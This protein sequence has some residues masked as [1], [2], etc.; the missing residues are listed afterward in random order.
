MKKIILVN[1]FVT[2]QLFCFSQNTALV[3]SPQNS[4]S[5]NSQN[6]SDSISVILSPGTNNITIINNLE[7]VIL[8]TNGVRLNSYCANHNVFILLID[9]NVYATPQLFYTHL[10]TATN[11]ATLLLK[12]GS[13]LDILP[14][15]ESKVTKKII[16]PDVEKALLDK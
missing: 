12:E 6:I 15:C 2:I 5:L 4:Q 14:F 11:I 7:S 1:L 16:N 8:T 10:K 9:K 3:S 13:Q